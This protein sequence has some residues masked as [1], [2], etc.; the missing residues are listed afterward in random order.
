MRTSI[1]IVLAVLVVV[2]TA[3]G[4]E[5]RSANYNLL[6][7]TGSDNGCSGTDCVAVLLVHGIYGTSHDANCQLTDPPGTD[8]YWR[9]LIDYLRTQPTVWSKVRIYIFRYMSD[10]GISTVEIGKALRSQ[11][12]QPPADCINCQ[13]L[14]RPFIVVAHSMGGIVARQFMNSQP[15]LS[16]PRGVDLV[17]GVITLATPHQGTPFANRVLRDKKAERLAGYDPLCASCPDPAAVF[18]SVDSL[19]W[20]IINHSSALAVNPDLPNRSDL[21]WDEHDD[22]FAEERNGLEPPQETNKSLGALAQSAP[23]AADDSRKLIV[24]GSSV[25]TQGYSSSF[26]ESVIQGLI[27]KGASIWPGLDRQTFE[28]KHSFLEASAAAAEQNLHAYLTDGFVPLSS[29]MKE[30][31]S[32]VNLRRQDLSDYDHQ[33][34]AGNQPIVDVRA[35]KNLELFNRVAADIDALVRFRAIPPRLLRLDVSPSVAAGGTTVTLT[36]RI[37]NGSRNPIL[38]TLKAVATGSGN[39]TVC[40]PF[41]ASIPSGSAGDVSVNRTLKLP[42]DFPAGPITVVGEILPGNEPRPCDV[43]LLPPGSLPATNLTSLTLF[44][45]PAYTTNPTVTLARARQDKQDYRIGETAQLQM[46][47]A[48]GVLAPSPFQTGGETTLATVFVPP[49]STFLWVVRPDG[50]VRYCYLDSTQ[51]LRE[52]TLPT[53]VL[54]HQPLITPGAFRRLL[55]TPRCWQER[56][57][58]MRR[59]IKVMSRLEAINFPRPLPSHIAF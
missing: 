34:M 6:A 58:G 44:V 17:S 47:T 39:K 10:A 36:Y 26:A 22:F 37:R 31:D 51:S 42:T 46:T 3:K 59:F 21:L 54:P 40:D 56:T 32:L 9:P 25:N 24:Y 7:L 45:P 19:F 35:S 57:R 20:D 33:D 43:S 16:A 41:V 29:A 53:P 49:V 27:G 14:K 1:A 13:E 30:G 23:K 50:N 12:D 38:A 8:C 4:D 52:S 11:I 55:S 5:I 48:A 2:G 18:D 15:S 28:A